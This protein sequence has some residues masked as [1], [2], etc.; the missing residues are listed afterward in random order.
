MGLTQEMLNAVIQSLLGKYPTLSKCE[1]HL[2]GTDLKSLKDELNGYVVTSG[3]LVNTDG[4][5]VDKYCY[6][7]VTVS[8]YESDTDY[9]Y[10]SAEGKEFEITTLEEI[11]E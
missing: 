11:I 10:I 2:T 4:F 1:L 5:I 3:S 7:G 9:T 6:A 8:C